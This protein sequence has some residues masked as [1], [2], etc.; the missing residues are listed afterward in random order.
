MAKSKVVIGPEETWL[1]SEARDWHIPL[2]MRYSSSEV[3]FAAMSTDLKFLA[4]R[5]I[6]LAFLRFSSNF[7]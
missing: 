1:L 4:E 3:K 5:L 7:R 2:D 6:P